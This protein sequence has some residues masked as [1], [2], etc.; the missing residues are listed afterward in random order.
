[1][2]KSNVDISK[3]PKF[4]TL[5]EAK[6]YFDHP[7]RGK[8]T[9]QGWETTKPPYAVY[10]YARNNGVEYFVDIFQDGTVVVIQR[11]NEENKDF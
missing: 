2:R 3:L 5:Q 10:T 1:M 9:F 11:G 4:T 7:S 6:D 8:L